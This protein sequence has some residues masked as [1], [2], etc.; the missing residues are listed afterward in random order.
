VILSWVPQGSY[1]NFTRILRGFA[2]TL[3]VFT[4]P[5]LAPARKLQWKLFSQLPV[6]LSPI[7]ALFF[8]RIIR[9]LI[10]NILYFF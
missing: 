4:E 7:I 1:N 10:H 2:G 6:D 9:N 8:I 3:H 5:F